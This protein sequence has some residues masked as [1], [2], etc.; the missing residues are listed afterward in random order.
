MLFGLRN[1]SRKRSNDKEMSR[2]CNILKSIRFT[3]RLVFT[4][5]N[6]LFSYGK[7]PKSVFNRSIK[8][9][10]LILPTL[11]F[12][13]TNNVTE[14]KLLRNEKKQKTSNSQLQFTKNIF[15][16]FLPGDEAGYQAFQSHVRQ[17]QT[18]VERFLPRPVQK[19]LQDILAGIQKIIGKNV[20]ESYCFRLSC[21]GSRVAFVQTTTNCYNNILYLNTI[22]VRATELL[23][24]SCIYTN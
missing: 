10:T 24:G 8:C 21:R 1:R 12:F 14:T 22:V 6:C 13:S 16:S 19:H 17:L 23:V 9:P 18:K 15:N 5:S 3:T 4:L 11:I 2:G 20:R 7:T